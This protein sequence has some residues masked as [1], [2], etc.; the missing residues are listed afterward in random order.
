MVE[1]ESFLIDNFNCCSFDTVKFY[2]LVNNEA[3]A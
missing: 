2:N 1:R 3:I